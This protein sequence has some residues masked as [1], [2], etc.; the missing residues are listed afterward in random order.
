M[1]DRYAPAGFGW[2]GGRACISS[3]SLEANI[4]ENQHLPSFSP[5]NLFAGV[6]YAEREL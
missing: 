5:G 1:K 2:K 6:Q 3:R 4:G